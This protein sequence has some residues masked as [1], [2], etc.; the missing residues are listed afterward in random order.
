MADTEVGKPEHAVSA[1]LGMAAGFAAGAYGA[2]AAMAWWHYG[3]PPR[4]SAA[5]YDPL[6][7]RL[8]PAYDVG[9]RHAATVAAPAELALDTATRLNVF[10]LP[11]TA[12]IVRA[13]ELIFGTSTE[14]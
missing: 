1:V 5:E 7:D 9:D 3:H 11:V 14:K 6:L 8:M 12:A 10:R 2:W 4:P 13:R